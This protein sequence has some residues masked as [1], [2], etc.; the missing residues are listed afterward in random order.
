MSTGFL[1]L[2]SCHHSDLPRPEPWNSGLHSCSNHV[3]PISQRPS[4]LA[5]CPPGGAQKLEAIRSPPNQSCISDKNKTPRGRRVYPR[6]IRRVWPW[7]KIYIDGNHFI[8][9]LGEE[10]Y[11]H[12]GYNKRSGLM[13]KQTIFLDE[14]IWFYNDVNT[15]F[16]ISQWIK[17]KI[18]EEISWNLSRWLQNV[19]GK[20]NVLE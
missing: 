8:N 10:L 14:K 13:E 18:S 17:G 15:A 19:S 1:D 7:E 5:W 3:L 9:I 12:D 2:S 6:N 16:Q 20:G 11:D 4:R